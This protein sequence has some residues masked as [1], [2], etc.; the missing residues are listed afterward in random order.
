MPR[1][2]ARAPVFRGPPGS[3]CAPW[4][5]APARR[6]SRRGA[7][8]K[9]VAAQRSP[10]DLGIDVSTAGSVCHLLGHFGKLEGVCVCKSL[11]GDL[12]VFC[13]LTT[14][15]ETSIYSTFANP[16]LCTLSGSSGAHFPRRGHGFRR[17][18][19]AA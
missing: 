3:S 15:G 5:P 1:T 17:W 11:F 13:I 16:E 6:G 8:G 10:L 4:A 9:C 18:E 14:V 19:S 7:R 12:V 2:S